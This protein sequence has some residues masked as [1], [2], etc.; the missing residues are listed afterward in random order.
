MRFRHKGLKR[1]FEDGDQRGVRADHLERIEQILAV[2]YKASR[3][4]DLNIPGWRLHQRKGRDR[5][6]SVDISGQWRILFHWD[7]ERGVLTM[8]TTCKTTE[9]KMRPV[10][11]GPIIARAITEGL[12]MTMADAA[13]SL[14]VARPHLHRVLSGRHGVTPEMAL[15]V[16]RLLGNGARI[17]LDLQVEYDLRM[18]RCRLADELEKIPEHHA[19]L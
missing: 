6:W 11:P 14:G 4:S 7:E 19:A 1:L 17:W 9:P 8:S 16:G 15:K 5:R 2:L 12:R 13:R 3:L 18:A 10:H